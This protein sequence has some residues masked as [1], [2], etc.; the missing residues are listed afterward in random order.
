[1]PMATATSTVADVCRTARE[2]KVQLAFVTLSA[3]PERRGVSEQDV[4]FGLITL[5]G[6][7]Y[8]SKLIRVPIELLQD[9]AFNIEAYLA[10]KMATRTSARRCSTGCCSTRRAW[11]PSQRRSD[12]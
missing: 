4:A 5:G 11:A 7:K 8:S 2:G 12:R 9:A 10:R 6:F 1:M 3:P